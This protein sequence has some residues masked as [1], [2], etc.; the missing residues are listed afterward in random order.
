M[1]S[2]RALLSFQID[3]FYISS[4]LQF[5]IPSTLPRNNN[6]CL[7]MASLDEFILAL[8]GQTTD[9]IEEEL[10]DF[11]AK[12]AE[13]GRVTSTPHSKSFCNRNRITIFT[14]T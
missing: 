9:V 14:I 11:Y 3:L 2:Q 1:A 10:W 13:R 4:S 7:A 6:F 12:T 8:I 5:E